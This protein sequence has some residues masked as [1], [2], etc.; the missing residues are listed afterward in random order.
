MAMLSRAS[1]DDNAS[2]LPRFPLFRPAKASEIR[3]YVV[4]VNSLSALGAA[5]LKAVLPALEGNGA[6]VPSCLVTSYA[7]DPAARV[8]PTLEESYLA[9]LLER[10]GSTG[11]KAIVYI[12]FL[13]APEQVDM[14]LAALKRSEPWIDCICVD[15]VCADNG[16]LYVEEAFLEAW[17]KLLV[18]ANWAF[19]NLTEAEKLTGCAG[20]EAVEL[21]GYLYPELSYIVTGI[22]SGLSLRCEMLAYGERIRF[23]HLAAPAAYG[24]AG[25]YFAAKFILGHLVQGL[26]PLQALRIAGNATSQAVRRSLAA[27]SASLL[28]PQSDGGGG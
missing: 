23:E 22:R 3:D 17:P 4:C 28:I 27:R 19:P 5:G 26:E 8:I 6:P 11:R 24:G 10:I 25:D 16:R 18:K 9:A 21:F 2:S 20:E 12:G 7:S 13:N 14:V 15:P 1:L